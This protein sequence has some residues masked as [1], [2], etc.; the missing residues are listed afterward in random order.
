MHSKTMCNSGNE[1][2]I[3]KPEFQNCYMLQCWTRPWS[4]MSSFPF[5]FSLFQKMYRSEQQYLCMLPWS[6]ERWRATNIC[7]LKLILYYNISADKQKHTSVSDN[8]IWI[9]AT[10]RF[11]ECYFQKALLIWAS[12]YVTKQATIYYST[13]PLM[14]TLQ[15]LVCYDE[16]DLWAFLQGDDVFP[17]KYSYGICCTCTHKKKERRGKSLPIWQQMPSVPRFLLMHVLSLALH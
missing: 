12:Q 9:P 8:S 3:L 4:H 5:S 15:F 6:K 17:Q 2:Q 16:P 13:L 11:Y 14:F 10:G 1:T 7:T